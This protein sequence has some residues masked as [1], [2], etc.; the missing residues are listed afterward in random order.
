MLYFKGPQFYHASYI[1]IVTDHST[2]IKNL[3]MQNIYRVAETVNKNVL[4]LE[5]TYPK[6]VNTQNVKDCIKHLNLFK[7]NELCPTRFH[8]NQSTKA[9]DDTEPPKNWK[10]FKSR[11]SSAV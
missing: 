3:E 11:S 6:T 10:E 8:P 4:I 9:K 2:N 1:V 7:V 5:I